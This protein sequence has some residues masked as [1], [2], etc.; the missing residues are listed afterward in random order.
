MM[1]NFPFAATLMNVPF[2]SKFSVLSIR[3]NV[4]NSKISIVPVKKMSILLT[5]RHLRQSEY[6]LIGAI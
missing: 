3:I 6:M 4:G 2:R 1:R 5:M